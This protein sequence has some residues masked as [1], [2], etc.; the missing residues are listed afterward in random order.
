MLRKIPT[1]PLCAG[2]L[3]LLVYLGTLSHGA[4]LASLSLTA[5][6]CGW[7][8]APLTDHPLFWLLTLPLHVLPAGWLPTGLN[9]FSAVCAALALGLLAA[10]VPLLPWHRRLDTLPAGR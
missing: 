4:T 6:L 8:D 7:D 10:S 5:K 1:F 3:A 2:L 9:L